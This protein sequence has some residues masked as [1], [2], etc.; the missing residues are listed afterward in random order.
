[1]HEPHE[2]K[3]TRSMNDARRQPLP[4]SC[5]LLYPGKF[6]QAAQTSRPR[7]RRAE[8]WRQKD[9]LSLFI[10]LPPFFC[11]CLWPVPPVPVRWA[12]CGARPTIPESFRRLRK[13]LVRASGGQKH[14]GRKIFS[15]SSFFCLHFSASVCGRSRQSQLA[16]RSAEHVLWVRRSCAR[17]FVVPTALP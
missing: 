15:P 6:S 3:A 17:S 7:F 16:G 14:G 2:S 9:I 8:T 13:L 1:M 12:F 11:L 10:F 5:I 4:L